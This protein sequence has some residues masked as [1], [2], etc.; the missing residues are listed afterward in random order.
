[1]KNYK[2]HAIAFG[3]TAAVLLIVA[4]I[5]TY[6]WMQLRKNIAK[7]TTK[8]AAPTS[9]AVNAAVEATNQAAAAIV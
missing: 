7:V 5:V 1:M 2:N 4:V 8:T 9:A 3:I 6:K